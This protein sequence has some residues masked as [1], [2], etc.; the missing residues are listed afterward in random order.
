M[1]KYKLINSSN[2]IFGV[3]TQND[4]MAWHG[5]FGQVVFATE[6]DGQFV[7]YKSRYYRDDWLRAVGNPD[8]DVELVRIVEISDLEYEVL[9]EIFAE[10]DDGIPE[11]EP[12]PEPEPVPDPEPEPG[13]DQVRAIV[14]DNMSRACETAIMDGVT[15][16]TADGEDHHFSLTVLDQINLLS[17]QMQVE[18]GDDPVPYRADGEMSRL[19]TA[20]EILSIIAAARI[21][22]TWHMLYL[23]CLRNYIASM[24]DIQQICE[25]EYGM[26]IPDEYK[27][28][29]FKYFFGG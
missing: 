1:G 29:L 23:D 27:T 12:D 21:H 11:E 19:F 10:S 8:L 6:E 15:T 5:R 20:D 18:A 22:K 28:D 4:F 7:Q 13:I 9:A 2:V 26:S 16:A 17:L 24:D 14:L 25:V 3:V